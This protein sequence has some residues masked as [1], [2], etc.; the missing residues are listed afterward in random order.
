M[1]TF[2]QEFSFFQKNYTL[3][4][5]YIPKINSKKNK[6]KQI[7]LLI[8]IAILGFGFWTDYL[9]WNKYITISIVVFA[10]FSLIGLHFQL[11]TA[12]VRKELKR[13]NLPIPKIFYAWRSK[14]LENKR[15]KHIKKKYKNVDSSLIQSYIDYAEYCLKKYN[16]DIFS[17]FEKITEFFGKNYISFILGLL[18]GLLSQSEFTKESFRTVISIITWIFGILF[19]SV[20]SWKYIIKGRLMASENYRS[21]QYKDY[22]YVMK[23]ILLMR[24][25]QK[26][27]SERD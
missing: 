24:M 12:I 6:E 25:E 10:L 19:I 7:Y 26:T 3:E 14:K 18:I 16:K 5:L 1:K 17:D 27:K 15:V 13:K 11:T 8:P 2:D 21:G 9:N 23:N 20:L 22:I 4:K